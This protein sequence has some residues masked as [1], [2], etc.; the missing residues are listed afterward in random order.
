M[1]SASIGSEVSPLVFALII[2]FISIDL[3]LSMVLAESAITWEQSAHLVEAN[4]NDVGRLPPEVET[5]Q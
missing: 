2:G 1:N 5:D 3:S 4:G